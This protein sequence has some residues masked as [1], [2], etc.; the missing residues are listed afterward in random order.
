MENSPHEAT[1]PLTQPYFDPRRLGRNNSDVSDHDASDVICILAPNSPLAYDAVLATMLAAPQHILQNEDLQ[2]ITPDDLL[3]PQFTPGNSSRDIALRISSQVKNP[4]AG[5]VFGRNKSRC[6]VLLVDDE[7]DRSVSNMHFKIFLNPQGILMLQDT[8]TNGTIVD[9]NHLRCKNKHGV[10]HEKPPMRM[11]D[12]GALITVIGKEKA[13]IK[14]LVRNPKRGDYEGAFLANLN[15]FISTRDKSQVSISA[16]SRQHTYG[17]HWHGGSNYNV[18]GLLGKGA[19]ATVYRLATTLEGVPY[20]AKELDKRRFI[21]NGV[22]DLKFDNEIRIMKGL[23][24]P[25]IVQYIDFH[26][27]EQWVYIIMEYLPHGEL[28]RYMQ[29][30]GPIPEE[31]ARI[32]TRQVLHALDYLHRRNITH[33]DIKPDNILIASFE[34]LIVKL[35]DFGLSKCVNDEETFLKTFCGTLLYCAPEIY[36]EY[37]TYQQG[38]NRKRRRVGEPSRRASPYDQ[39]VDMWSFG[40]VLFHIMCGKAPIIGR[41]DDKGAQMLNN[42]M[43]KDVNFDPLRSAGIS[44]QAI[45]FIGQLLNRNPLM[46]PNEKD[47]LYHPW[48]RDV[49]DNI[50]YMDEDEVPIRLHS[51]LEALEEVEED[52]LD[53]E[54][55]GAYRAIFGLPELQIDAPLPGDANRL[56]P[57]FSAKRRRLSTAGPPKTQAFDYADEADVVYPR[58]PETEL[59]ADLPRTGNPKPTPTSRA[60]RLFGEITPSVLRSSGVLGQAAPPQADV[61]TLRDGVEQISV[62]DF[63]TF[64]TTQPR[65]T[66]EANSERQLQYPQALPMPPLPSSAPSLLGAEAQIGLLN[67]ASPDTEASE[68][69]TPDTTNPMTPNTREVTP[70]DSE[71]KSQPSQ[72][73]ANEA[74]NVSPARIPFSPLIDLDELEDEVAHAAS[75]RAREASRIRIREQKASTF[76]TNV[77]S[78]YQSAP[79]ELARTVDAQ[80]ENEVVSRATASVANLT[81]RFEEPQS[82]SPYSSTNSTRDGFAKPLPR[83]GK[84]ST[85]PGSTTNT[86]VYLNGRMTS[87]GRDPRSRVGSNIVHTDKNDV[88]VPKRALQITFWAPGMEERIERGEDWMTVP[89]ICTIVSTSTSRCIW[90]NDVELRAQSKEGDARLYGKIYTG[91][92]VTI[93][94]SQDPKEGFLK[95]RVEIG[96]GDSARK[97]PETEQGFQV[98]RETVHHQRGLEANSMKAG[99]KENKSEPILGGSPT[100]AALKGN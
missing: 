100:A 24:H 50:D 52:F 62:H 5:F 13:E 67:M 47:C 27:H 63:V 4:A 77:E 28:S 95:F 16:A 3:S 31:E 61:P 82:Q 85:L 41:G 75:M 10:R 93:F 64:N 25:N 92:V 26:D 34:P 54:E 69:T 58:L 84:F 35:S 65:Q 29:E 56:D 91:D 88:R 70:N 36:P 38:E 57:R 37:A 53:D 22:L 2:G 21:K 39:S 43:T 9:D 14:F 40:A 51:G 18:V 11:I 17:M 76:H 44:E 72:P 33:R 23:R 59:E 68:G 7:E 80:R 19:F 42:I 97:R 73:T 46:R 48:I 94:K 87:W 71:P 89:G 6:D 83:L 79:A 74:A 55:E 99:E 98:K 96:Y 8:S 30:K 78:A 60:D 49:H 66:S 12:N 90:V 1:Q 20:A 86:T 15:K 81:T 45:D 32:I